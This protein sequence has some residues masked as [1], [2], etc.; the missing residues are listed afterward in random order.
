MTLP[1]DLTW[2]GQSAVR[3]DFD[4]AVVLIDPF[5]TDAPQYDGTLEAAMEGCT[6]VLLTHGHQDHIGNTKEIIDATGAELVAGFEVC[7]YIGAKNVNPGN[8]GGKL[9]C[10]AFTVAFTQAF[11]SSGLVG[12]DSS[13]YL[14]NPMGL[15]V[16]PKNGPSIY[17]MGDTDIFGDMALIEELH[18]PEIGIVP[19]GDRFT[20]GGRVAALACQRY[21][22][23]RKVLPVHFGT[24]PI[25]DQTPDKFI[26]ALGP[27]GPEVLTPTGGER[28]KLS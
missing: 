8:I 24:F 27:N 19:I 18:A 25:L 26:D 3:L 20:M 7:N 14:G 13:V 2:F 22:N 15:V 17:H 12:K 10:G 21:F 16:T 1:V 23:F 4:G 9:D 5:I 6:H 11:H 28:I